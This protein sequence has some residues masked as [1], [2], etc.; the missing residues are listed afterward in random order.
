MRN[1]SVIALYCLC[2]RH[3][4]NN[5]VFKV[6]TIIVLHRLQIQILVILCTYRWVYQFGITYSHIHIHMFPISHK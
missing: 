4:T 3:Y 5:K 1:A 6:S 2:V